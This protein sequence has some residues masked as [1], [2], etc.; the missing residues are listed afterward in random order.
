[1][2]ILKQQSYV[3]CPLLM[4]MQTANDIM[5]YH[6]AKATTARPMTLETFSKMQSHVYKHWMYICEIT[7]VMCIECVMEDLMC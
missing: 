4:Q 6:R 7:R 5:E 2:K 1:M 3:I